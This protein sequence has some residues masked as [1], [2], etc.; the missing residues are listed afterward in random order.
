MSIQRDPDYDFVPPL[1]KPGEATWVRK[2]TQCG[3]CG[4]KFEYGHAYGF[5]CANSRCPTGWGVKSM[6]ATTRLSPVTDAMVERAWAAIVGRD[7]APQCFNA[8]I[9]RADLRTALEAVISPAQPSASPDPEAW[10][11]D[12][13]SAATINPMI[14][15]GWKAQGG[16]AI[17]LYA[18]PQAAS[19]AQTATREALEEINAL[20]SNGDRPTVNER[21]AFEHFT[22]LNRLLLN[23]RDIARRALSSVPSTL[24]APP[25][26]Q[27]MEEAAADNFGLT[28][29]DL[30]EDDDG[31][32]P[33][34]QREGK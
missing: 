30:D 15:A 19:V 2:G 26:G 6:T 9:I 5:C 20:I 31:S 14:A 3:E 4:M 32:M 22:A 13:G 18:A 11:R 34:K 28:A 17:P 25:G 10:M 29:D 16:R 1:P 21:N 8:S 27:T 24:R 23:I 7:I 33:S 12:D